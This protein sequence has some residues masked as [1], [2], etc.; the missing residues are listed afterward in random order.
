MQ[1][2]HEK[3]SSDEGE[4]ALVASAPVDATAAT[5]ASLAFFILDDFVG[6]DSVTMEECRADFL[7]S[8]QT[9]TVVSFCASRFQKF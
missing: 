3:S 2:L 9:N 5:V 8:L 6:P 7:G 1:M 4:E